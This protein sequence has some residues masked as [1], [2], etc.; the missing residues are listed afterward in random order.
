MAS[1]RTETL[2][3]GPWA[4]TLLGRCPTMCGAKIKLAWQGAQGPPV[5]DLP[6]HSLKV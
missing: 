5:G 4:M 6:L 3:A 2:T 1:L